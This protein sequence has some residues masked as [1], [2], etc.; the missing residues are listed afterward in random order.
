MKN[1]Y[2][3]IYKYLFT[4]LFIKCSSTSIQN[5]SHWIQNLLHN[6]LVLVS[7]TLFLYLKSLKK[8]V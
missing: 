1:I 7:T 5:R 6:I 3:V 2:A 4:Y 8:K